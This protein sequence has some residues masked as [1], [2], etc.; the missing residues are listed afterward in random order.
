MPILD[1]GDFNKQAISGNRKYMEMAERGEDYIAIKREAEKDGLM[2]ENLSQV[3][4]MADRIIMQK[5]LNKD[6]KAGAYFKLLIGC[7]IGIGCTILA[8]VLFFNAG[9]ISFF[10]I[11]AIGFGFLMLFRG[12]RD[13]KK[14]S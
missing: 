9:I 2:G 14:L 1:E 10:N 7:F 5:S 13:L 3:M 11:I 4:A 12:L 6:K 8:I